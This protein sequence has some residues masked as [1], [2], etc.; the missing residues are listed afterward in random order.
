[1]NQFGSPSYSYVLSG[2]EYS[3]IA[4]VPD[5]KSHIPGR[6]HVLNSFNLGFHNSTRKVFLKSNYDNSNSYYVFRKYLFHDHRKN[7][8]AESELL[9]MPES[10]CE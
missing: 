3:N 7:R 10:A 2:R 8:T 1:M 6:V 9:G 4:D 5:I